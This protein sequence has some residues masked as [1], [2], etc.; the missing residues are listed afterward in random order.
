VFSL[1]R[2]LLMGAKIAVCI[3]TGIIADKYITRF[4]VLSKSE[5]NRTGSLA[6][7]CKGEPK[8][9]VFKSKGFFI[10]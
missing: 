7:A 5:R 1:D 10:N 4:S 8:K 6:P 2:G 9:D 3:F